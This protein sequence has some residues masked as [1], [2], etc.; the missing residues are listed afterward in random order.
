[1]HDVVVIGMGAAGEAA[2][3]KAGEL[4]GSV[5]AVEREL[6]GGECAFWA[7]MPSKTLLDQAHR[8]GLGADVL[9]KHASDRR[10]WMISREDIDEPD[11][12]GHVRAAEEHGAEVLRG[13]ARVVG[14]GRIEVRGDGGAPRTLEARSL[15]V[16]AGA[17]PVVPPIDG[18]QEAGYWTSRDGTSLRDLP[19]SIVVLGGGP[20]G[21]EL[22]QVYARFGVGTTVVEGEERLLPRDHPNSS[23]ALAEQL[24]E[25]GIE[26]R[27]GVMA[28]AVE[29]GG[30]GRRVT[31][32]DG[33]TVE[34]A[35]L[36]VAVGRRPANLRELGLEEAGVELDDR[37][38]PPP[39]DDQL[40]IA[41][42]VRVAGDVA[43]GLQFT[44]IADYEGR[45]AAAAALGRDVR[46]DLSAVPRT[47]FTDPETAAVGLM[48]DEAREQDIDAFEVSE[49]FAGTSRGVT[50]EGARGHVTLVVDKERG[51]LVGAFAACPGASE[52]IHEYVLAIRAGVPVRVLAE[53][54]HAFPTAARTGMFLADEAAEQLG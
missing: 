24:A 31:L 17:E 3:A 43:G 8:R 23:R 13:T 40:R 21:L 46:A 44:H 9:W 25:D 18:L 38:A 11:D 12:T 52:L 32:S 30:A 45:V 5:A 36:L 35:E 7:C 26:V 53:A 2:V 41:E 22:A 33:S 50:I 42:S 16:A 20:V 39:H 47:A 49:D 4:G 29:R 37:G 19:S 54:V 27:T 6:V 48:V 34:G 15:I 28:T 51:V 14:P 10:D 1:M